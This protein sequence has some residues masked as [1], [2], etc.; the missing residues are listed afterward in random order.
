VKVVVTGGAGFVGSHIVERLKIE[1]EVSV[2]DRPAWDMCADPEYVTASDMRAMWSKLD[3]CEVVVHAAALPEVRAWTD[4]IWSANVDGTRRVLDHMTARAVN[5]MIFISSSCV[6]G[7]DDRLGNRE[8]RPVSLYGASKIAGE[9]IVS[10]WA[11]LKPG[12]RRWCALRPVACYGHGYVRGHL[13]DFA[14]RYRRDGRVSALDCGI[15]RKDG[16]HAADV[17]DAVAILI[18][19]K[20]AHGPYD[21]AAEPWSWRDSARIMGINVESN[22]SARGF[23]GDAIRERGFDCEKLRAAGWQPRRSCELGV[24]E[25]LASLGWVRPGWVRP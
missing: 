23:V 4:E 11:A 3:G 25:A 16:V 21:I 7:D 24:R 15:Q 19:D 13:K 22:G 2:L 17:A 20:T 6:Y 9:A 12:Q 1:H 14:D 5:I 8:V 10:A 18:A